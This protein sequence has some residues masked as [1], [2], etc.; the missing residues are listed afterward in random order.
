MKLRTKLALC[1]GVAA[2]G[3][4]TTFGSAV[5]N[6]N[7]GPLDTAADAVREGERK[8]ALAAPGYI[9]E[10]ASDRLRNQEYGGAFGE[11]AMY[12]GLLGLAIP[13]RKEKKNG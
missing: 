12:G 10:D 3:A 5:V 7:R 13:R 4:C 2:L 11:M 9:L 1:L 8:G 6:N